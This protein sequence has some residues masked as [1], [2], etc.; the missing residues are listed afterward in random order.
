MSERC[1][2]C[3][4]EWRALKS[5]LAAAIAA[6][7]WSRIWPGKAGTTVRA[8]ACTARGSATANFA[9]PPRAQRRSM[10]LGAA[11]RGTYRRAVSGDG[12]CCACPD[13]NERALDYYVVYRRSPDAT[14]RA[15]RCDWLLAVPKPPILIRKRGVRCSTIKNDFC[16][17]GVVWS[18]IAEAVAGKRR[19]KI[20]MK[21]HVLR[22]NQCRSPKRGYA[23]ARA[24]VA[25]TAIC[26]KPNRK[27]SAS[28][29]RRRKTSR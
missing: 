18:S 12:R 11:R 1:P 21:R 25:D 29:R 24:R 8:A 28:D 26:L 14:G 6:L 15:D 16:A 17:L 4:A 22:R 19:K 23:P 10:R 9:T 2:G 3:G 27:A 5:S 7:P 20:M 13:R